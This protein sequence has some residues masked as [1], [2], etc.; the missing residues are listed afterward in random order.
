MH[1][2]F[3]DRYHERFDILHVNTLPPHAYVQP[4]AN[5]SEALD[6]LRQHTPGTRTQMLNGVWRFRYYPC[7]ETMPDDLPEQM[8]SEDCTIMVPGCWQLQGYGTPAYI[9]YRYPIPFD[10]PFVPSDN[11][12][13][14]YARTFHIENKKGWSWILSFEGVDSC[15]YLYINGVFAGYSQ[16]SHNMSEFNIDSYVCDGDNELCVVVLQWCDGTY[17]ECQDKWRLSGIFRNVYLTKRPQKHI[18]DFR[19]ETFLGETPDRA[20]VRVAIDTEAPGCLSFLNPD[21]VTICSYPFEASPESRIVIPVEKPLLWC[22]E[23]PTLYTLLLET[24]EESLADYV[25]IREIRIKNGVFLVNRVPVRLH[26]VNRH[27]FDPETGAY[28]SPARMLEDLQL[29]KR[30]NVDAVRTSHYPNAPLFPRLCDELGFYLISEAD[31]ECH[32]S[33]DGCME[34]NIQ[35]IAAVCAMPEFGP[36]MKDRVLGMVARDRNRP[37]IILWSLGNESGYSENF[38][39]IMHQLE[40]VDPGRPVHYECTSL[41][42]PGQNVPD[43]FRLRSR[44]YPSFEWMEEYADEQEAL[45]PEMRRPLVLCEYSHAMG[46]GPGDLEDYWR[47]IHA[48]DCMMGAFVWEWCEHGISAGSAGKYRYGGDFGE[49]VHDGNFCVDGLV[50]PDRRPN[51]GALEMKQVYRPLRVVKGRNGTLIFENMMSFTALRGRYDLVCEILENGRVA[52]TVEPAFDLAPHERKEVPVS[53]FTESEKMP[54]IPAPQSLRFVLFETDCRAEPV[55]FDQI[56]IS[57]I[58]VPSPSKHVRGSI[59]KIHETRASLSVTGKDFQIIFSK[60]TSLPVTFRKGELELLAAPI[61]WTCMRSPTDNDIRVRADW[62]KYHLA[63]LQPKVSSWRYEIAESGEVLIHSRIS[64]GYAV[65]RPIIT[66]RQT[67]RITSDGFVRFLQDAAVEPRYPGVLPRFGLHLRLPDVFNRIRY[68]GLGP[69]ES[70]PDKHQ[71]SWLGEFSGEVSREYYPYIRPQE[72]GSHAGCRF[73]EVSDGRHSLQAWSDRPF[74]FQAIPYT[75]EELMTCTHN[76]ELKPSGYTE[77]CLDARQ[78]GIGSESCCTVMADRYRF[79][80]KHFALDITLGFS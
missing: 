62:E 74:S 47:I 36:A 11:P 1:H 79:S 9:N 61:S 52:R 56:L 20:E 53:L 51:P 22:A 45:P 71:A 66:L 80:E 76:D 54:C 25:G 58:T 29:M 34:D 38:R 67:C 31:I 48:H 50:S 17:L 42:L 75:V 60:L 69:G 5:R 49:I 14:V 57:E 8:K 18:Y 21:G 39:V 41:T 16:V 35:C 77:V 44:M 63:C 12:A 15:F 27:D 43:E 70:Y 78:H 2:I 23:K 7:A 26:G 73:A 28:V 46:N 10:P 68:L 32:G 64:L 13:G 24:A 33:A 4:A 65:Y 30:L 59:P 6:G 3:E 72:S 55:C 37:S 40:T 19:V